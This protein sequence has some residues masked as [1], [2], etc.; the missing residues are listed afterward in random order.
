MFEFARILVLVTGLW[1][2]ASLGFQIS[3][4][5]AYGRRVY[6]APTVGAAWRGVLYALGPGMSPTAKESTRQNLPVYFTG[7]GYHLGI[8]LALL[9]LILGVAGIT[10][11]T[12]GLLLHIIQI[13]TLI[14]TLCGVGLMIRRLGSCNLR[15]L[16]CPDDYLGNLL[17][18]VFVA[19]TFARTLWP[20][21]LPVL[22]IEASLLFLYAPLGKI[23]HCAF[24]FL[25]RFHTGA[26]F[27]RRGTF[28]LTHHGDDTHNPASVVGGH[29]HA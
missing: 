14:G 3:R 21:L 16:S 5:R 9:S 27:G 17:T 25:T 28:P 4:V 12:R 22:A 19:L 26:F 15:G 1:A 8:F 6:F 2:L 23:R 13:V 24:F 10:Q 11:I 29:G 20:A 18:T 7:V